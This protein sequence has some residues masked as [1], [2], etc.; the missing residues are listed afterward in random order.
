MSEANKD[1]GCLIWLIRLYRHPS[2]LWRT[3]LK[4]R[5]TTNPQIISMPDFAAD[6]EKY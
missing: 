2:H 5:L 3:P 6:S 4:G 1:G